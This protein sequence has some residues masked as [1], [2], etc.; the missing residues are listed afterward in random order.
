M[1][2][3]RE[4]RYSKEY[5][6]RCMDEIIKKMKSQDYSEAVQDSRIMLE[7]L[8]KDLSERSGLEY[9]DGDLKS[10]FENLKV[11]MDLKKIMEGLTLV[12][13]GIDEI[14]EEHITKSEAKLYLS[15]SVIISE[16]LLDRY[17]ETEK[18]RVW[19]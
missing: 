7:M 17:L 6:D 1:K 11:E 15:S 4:G 2:V 19:S 3:K 18:N 12:I 13:N 16:F 10:S 9:I 8:V 5:A 14:P